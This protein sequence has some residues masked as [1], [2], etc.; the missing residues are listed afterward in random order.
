MKIENFR[1]K[2]QN[3]RA[4]VL[5][6]VTW[7][8]SDR[9]AREIFF[10]TDEK[11][12]ESLS[13][14]PHAFLVGCILPAMHH[15]ENRV[16]LNTEI[17][18]ELREGLNTVMNWIRHWFEPNRNIV[19]IEAKVQFYPQTPLMPKRAGMFF[20]GGIDSLAILRANRLN[21]PL[22][23]PGS[24]QDGLIIYGQNIESDN[25]P[26][27]F[28]KAV[29]ALSEVAM[30]SG[31]T[32]I[33]IYTNIR[34]LDEDAEFFVTQFHGAILGAV[35]HAL[36]HR[37]TSVSISSSDEIP[38]LSLL[39]RQH[40]KPFGSHPLIDPNYSSSDLQIRHE[41]ITLSRLDKTKL[42]AD[43][44]VALQNIK[45]CQPNWPSENCG[46]CEKC[47]RTM[48]ALLALG[49]LKRTKAFPQ[50]DVFEDLVSKVNIK[51]P[52]MKNSY[53][54]EDNYLELIPAL[55]KIGRKDLVQAIEQL[56]ERYYNPIKPKV[57][58][59]TKIWQFDQKY[60]KGSLTKLKHLRFS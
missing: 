17:C 57:S 24:I 41:G 48:L 49:A 56:I 6:T 47:V 37:L 42:V 12:S 39:K 9:P 55:M 38:T 23:H 3:G 13:C 26:E 1:T 25:R 10:E 46:R 34:S 11:F 40:F 59:Q 35:A 7:E 29:N 16:Y 2:K 8:E 21:F 14:N 19:S 50:D 36:A 28:E 45:V 31:I 4:K 5:A 32:L 51:R 52:I 33:P 30:D 58:L 53:S 60:L 27:S 15:G 22:E 54:V 44:D 18:P 43:W 20:S